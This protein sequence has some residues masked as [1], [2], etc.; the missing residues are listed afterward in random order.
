MAVPRCGK[1]G[2]RKPPIEQRAQLQDDKGRQLQLG[3]EWHLGLVV[4]QQRHSYVPDPAP[5][6]PIENGHKTDL[7]MKPCH[8]LSQFLWVC[9]RSCKDYDQQGT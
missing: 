2:L 4:L 6:G 7:K 1:K 3:W 8:F 5:E 9:L